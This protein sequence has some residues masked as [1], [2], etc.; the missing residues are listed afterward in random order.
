MNAP[1]S[2]FSHIIQQ[3]A[4]NASFLWVLR[5]R[6]RRE[7]HVF[8]E[9]IAE[10][11]ERIQANLDGLSQYGDDAWAIAQA[12][13]EF[14]QGGE[15]F[16]LGYLA[17]SSEDVAKI[18]Y[19]TEFALQNDDT[20]KGLVSALAWLPGQKV[21]PWV[22]QFFHSKNLEHKRLALAAC[23]VRKE[24]PAGFLNAIFEREDCVT[25][26]PLL[27]EALR[28]AGFFKRADL[29]EL[30]KKFLANPEP[31]VLFWAIYAS[32][33]TGNLAA[34]ELLNTYCTTT[35]ESLASLQ[36]RALL[37]AMWYLPLQLARSWIGSWVE[38]GLLRTAIK[39]C[40]FL[41]DTVSIPWLKSQME[42]KE[43]NR[44]A[45]E[46]F[47]LITQQH[48]PEGKA[49]I[50]DAEEETSEDDNLPWV[51]PKQIAPAPE[52]TGERERTAMRYTLQKE[53]L[54]LIEK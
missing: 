5:G 44:V 19:A 20:F 40:G 8:P 32:L 10:L 29:I 14:P 53:F 48:A 6:Q 30:P 33:Q 49:L 2:A 25:H 54:S 3:L 34:A 51:D 7:P 9:H 22:K 52:T 26:A 4:D 28:T 47:Y 35:D 18:Q 16:C 45:G 36:E 38:Q 1:A 21:H 15:A 42:V 13:G 50:T 46:A 12:N 24:D 27:A 17:F 11:D 31:Q 39:A 37:L 41:G 43:L 23:R